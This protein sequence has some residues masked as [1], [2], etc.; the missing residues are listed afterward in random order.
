M[1]RMSEGKVW[2][3]D[4]LLAMTPNERHEIV[5]SCI[6]TDLSQVPPSLLKQARADIWAH[7]SETT[8][9]GQ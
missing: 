5:Q 2:S 4:E 7:I 6:V 8:P 1:T 3:A 9:A